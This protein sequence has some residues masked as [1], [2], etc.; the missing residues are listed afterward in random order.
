M[1][2]YRAKYL[3]AVPEDVTIQ[4][5]K[6]GV[7]QGTSTSEIVPEYPPDYQDP[8]DDDMSRLKDMGPDV[9]VTDTYRP[10][11]EDDR[12]REPGKRTQERNY[13]EEDYYSNLDYE[14]TQDPGFTWPDRY[15]WDQY[16]S[17]YYY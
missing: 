14:R 4:R 3:L 9:D 10:A 16:D 6:F 17:G 2:N 1:T 8:Y 11:R 5:S 12:D 13:S 15:S 7:L